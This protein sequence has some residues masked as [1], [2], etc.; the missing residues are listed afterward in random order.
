M[1]TTETTTP[2]TR[3]KAGN[4]PARCCV[5]NP[6]DTHT[7]HEPEPLDEAVIAVAAERDVDPHALDDHVTA[8]HGWEPHDVGFDQAVTI[9]A[10]CL[11][12]GECR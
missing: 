12:R 5:G 8:V 9:A 2:V 3:C 6:W 1:D 10:Y 11:I 7:M 4:D